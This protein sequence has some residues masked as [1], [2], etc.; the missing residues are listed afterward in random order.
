MT[1]PAPARRRLDQ[2][3]GS[4]G[5][6]R[7]AE[8]PRLCR[9]G[10]VT[11]RDGTV[12]RQAA[13]KVAPRD[14]LLDGSPLPYPE[15]LFILLHKPLGYVC[16]HDANEGDLVY[17]LLP[18]SWRNR[19]P[20]VSTI[21]RLD[22]DTSGVLLLTDDGQAAHRLAS[23]ASHV[24]KSYLATVDHPLD[25]SLT[26][27]FAEGIALRGERTPCAPAAFEMLSETQAR[28]TV[29]EGRYHMVRRMLAACGWK[30][31]ALHRERFGR[32]QLDDLAPGQWRDT[33]D[34]D[35]RIRMP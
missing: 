8:V 12:L 21:G 20:S 23:P 28:V 24:E 3:L 14:V 18:A 10:R 13:T 6:A 11:L 2:C 19:R 31:T 16:S 9:D 29:C 25:P 35:G 4:L 32:Y 26:A 22:K 33:P 15:G 27:R 5:V 30:V 7:R 1:T 17:D 34:P